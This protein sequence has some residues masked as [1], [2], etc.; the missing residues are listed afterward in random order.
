MPH[1]VLLGNL[2]MEEVFRRF[3]PVFAKTDR[4]IVKATDSYI[5]RGGR[6]MLVDS[7]AIEGGEQTRFMMEISQREDGLLVEL[8]SGLEVKSSEGVKIVL[9]ETSKQLLETFPELKVGETDLQSY[10]D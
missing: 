6:C 2:E 8:W 1:V 7:L 9:A 3:K 4:G 10:M 5:D